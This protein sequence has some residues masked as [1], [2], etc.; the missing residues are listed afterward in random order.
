MKLYIVDAFTETLFGG[1]TAGVALVGGEWPADE[2]MRLLARELRYSETA[3]V[4]REGGGFRIRYFTPE[5]E[6]EL[7][8]HAT[9]GSFVALHDAG[10]PDGSYA[11]ATLA[12]PITVDTAGGRVLMDMA[13]P[14]FI[15]AVPAGRVGELYASL[16][17]TEAAMADGL[18]P[19]MVSTGLPDIM[20]SV[21]DAAALAAVKADFRRVSA[22]SEEFDCVGVHV[23]C[24]AADAAAHCRNF[25]PLY[26]IPEE[27]ATGTS[28]GALTYYLWRHGRIEPGAENVFVQGEA[29]GRPSV[30]RTRL[31]TGGEK[32]A[33][34]VRVGGGG[35]IVCRGEISL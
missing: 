35:V 34:T 25:A 33:V 19:E 27:S 1:N 26:G 9:V 6:V 29:M 13:P 21:R 14:R 4:R 3:F 22:L 23:F 32:N 20:L 7:C 24:P 31:T 17:I 5:A 11:V 15:G 28:N 30:I 16:G 8:G 18:P 12:G 2:A 10:L